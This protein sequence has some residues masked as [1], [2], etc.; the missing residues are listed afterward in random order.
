[1]IEFDAYLL[2][3]G[4]L[5]GLLTGTAGGLLAGLAGLGGGLIYVPVFYALMPGEAGTISAPV[6]AS[7][8]AIIFTGFFSTRVHWRLGHV[9]IAAFRQLIPGLVLGASLGLWLT[10]KIPEAVVLA[11][12]ALLD[13]WIAWDYGR[14]VRP[15]GITSLPELYAGPIGYISGMLG[16]GG[17]TMLVPLLRR[18]LPLRQ[19][20]GTS[21]L[22]GMVMAAS[23]VII[24]L[25]LESGWRTV[26]GHRILFLAGAWL[27]ILL[28]LPRATHWGAA[29]HDMLSEEMI[30]LSLKIL[31]TT[32]SGGLLVATLWRVLT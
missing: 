22:C 16:I 23:A 18:S 6:M 14:D 31:F 11:G 10:L 20:V 30:R 9:D 25:L 27:G 24:N 17:G 21:A 5:A 7:M 12:L 32:L 15:G 19:A 13:G 26:L 1:M 4:L 8:G 3:Y 28:M 2:A 29:L